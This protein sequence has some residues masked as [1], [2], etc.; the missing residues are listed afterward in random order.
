M[1]IRDI[2]YFKAVAEHGNVGR[3]ADALNLSATALSKSLRRLEKSVGAK[4]VKRTSRG[5]E[6]TAVGDALIARSGKLQLALEDI[7]H[8][9]ADLGSG[10]S[11][12]VKVGH[13]V[14]LCEYCVSDACSALREDA[15]DISIS[16]T[17]LHGSQTMTAVRTGQVDFLVHSI[18]VPIPI[19]LVCEELFRDHRIVYAS[20]SHPLARRKRVTLAELVR[21]SWASEFGPT[22]WNQ[23]CELFEANSLNT[24]KLLLQSN[25]LELRFAAV[26][27]SFLVTHGSSLL[28]R[29]AKQRF[30]FA[31]LPVE[32]WHFER[33]VGVYYRKDGYLSPAAKRMIKILKE[34]GRAITEGSASPF[35]SGRISA[36]R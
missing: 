1:E 26:A 23:I 11:G 36:T 29:R 25:S 30:R 20:A 8:E 9:A 34:Q 7:R 4:L 16:V 31:E 2:R 32:G 5:V 27:T 18:R 13:T 22:T 24:P 15:P 17:A 14:G 35:H 33:Q 28:L 21:E 10:R 3:A 12:H 6:L 19:E